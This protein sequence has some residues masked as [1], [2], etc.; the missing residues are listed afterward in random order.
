MVE[1]TKEQKSKLFNTLTLACE[2]EEIKTT[3]DLDKMGNITSIKLSYEGID[4]YIDDIEIMG[5]S[6][7]FRQ[8]NTVNNYWGAKA[9]INFIKNNKW[10]SK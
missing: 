2:R 7:L 9:L 1:L 8:A 5:L 6:I 4:C 3:N 10:G